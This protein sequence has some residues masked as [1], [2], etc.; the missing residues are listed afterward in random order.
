M[1]IPAGGHDS[2]TAG[3]PGLPPSLLRRRPN[4]KPGFYVVCDDFVTGPHKTVEAATDRR[5]TI[6]DHRMCPLPH[7]IVS[8]P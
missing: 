8:V 6:E 7:E 1:V 5:Q 2:G 3:T 4:P